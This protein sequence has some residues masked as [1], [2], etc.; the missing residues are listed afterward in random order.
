M[1]IY[2]LQNSAES[3]ADV[4]PFKKFT[5]DYVQ[6]PEELA[7]DYFDKKIHPE[8]KLSFGTQQFV[9]PCGKSLA[10]FDYKARTAHFYR[11]GFLRRNARIPEQFRFCWDPE[12]D[13][14]PKPK[15]PGM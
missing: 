7:P 15:L 10:Y 6:E 13:P 5:L 3:T 4:W 14:F 8:W 12:F 1:P 9:T 2:N 11:R